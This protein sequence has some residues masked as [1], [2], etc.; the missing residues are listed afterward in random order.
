[1]VPVIVPPLAASAGN[2]LLELHWREAI[3]INVVMIKR[4]KHHIAV[5]GKEQIETLIHAHDMLF[6]VA[7]KRREKEHLEQMKGK[8]ENA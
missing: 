4:G 2:T 5:P 1:M 6:I 7:H 3:G 8:K